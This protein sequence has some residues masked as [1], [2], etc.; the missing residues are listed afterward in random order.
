MKKEKDGQE[1]KIERRRGRCRKER[2]GERERKRERGRE[3]D[4]ETG[5]RGPEGGRYI[6][7]KTLLV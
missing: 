1:G 7:S 5:R 2:K 3:G 4:R 6:G